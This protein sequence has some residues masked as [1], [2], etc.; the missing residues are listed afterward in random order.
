MTPDWEMSD[1]EEALNSLKSGKCRD[2]EGIIREV[3]KEES[4]GNALKLSLLILFNKIKRS[5]IFP[6]FVQNINIC[7]IYKGKGD[8]N[9]LEADR[10]I[11]LMTIFRTML[12][13]MVYK[14]KY[15]IIEKAMSDSILGLRKDEHQKSYFCG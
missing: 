12:I 6:A 7:A 8:D 13:K 3:F 15:P 4:V 1:L 9:D 5:R 2:P 10:G 14:D 11:F